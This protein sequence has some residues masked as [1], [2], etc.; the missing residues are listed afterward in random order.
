MVAL[1]IDE[2]NFMKEKAKSVISKFL[3]R[4]IPELAEEA[5]NAITV[6]KNDCI[7]EEKLVFSYKL[8]TKFLVSTKPDFAIYY[9]NNGVVN[10]RVSF[11]DFE[12]FKREALELQPKF[13]AIF[14]I[15]TNRDNI[16]VRK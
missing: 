9:V 16:A 12:V 10:S 6:S 8:H 1:P 3:N 5:P 4:V 15:N 13:P 7:R 14:A 2:N 11:K